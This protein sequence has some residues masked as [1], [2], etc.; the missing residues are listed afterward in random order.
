MDCTAFDGNLNNVSQPVAAIWKWDE[1]QETRSVHYMDL[2][3]TDLKLYD[4]QINQL[5]ILQ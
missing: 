5:P 3:Q 2:K 1:Q 4:S